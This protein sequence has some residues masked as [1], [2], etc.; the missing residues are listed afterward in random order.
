[1]AATA[2][3]LAAFGRFNYLG[4]KG[5]GGVAHIHPLM[6]PGAATESQKAVIKYFLVV[7]LLFLAQVMVGGAAAHFRADPGSFYGIDLARYFP[8]NILRTWHLQLAIFW[9]ATAYVA[10]GLF[11]APAL[12]GKEPE[13]QAK[14]ANILFWAL[15]L[16]V[17]G[18]LLGEF[19][20]IRQ[21]LGNLWFWFGHQGWEYLDLGRGWQ[22]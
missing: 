21:L 13:G 7:T 1:L 5:E 17:A 3:V 9:I 11:L 2:L 20:G 8:S 22:F 12:G 14:G 4:W 19:L 10:G 6:I 18:S 15:V 16:V